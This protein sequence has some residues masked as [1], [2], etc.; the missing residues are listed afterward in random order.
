[1]RQRSGGSSTSQGYK[2]LSTFDA[3]QLGV[4]FSFRAG[5]NAA[6]SLVSS[7]RR[8]PSRVLSG[9]FELAGSLWQ[10]SQRP[11]VGATRLIRSKCPLD[12]GM[13]EG[14]FVWTHCPEPQLTAGGRITHRTRL[15]SPISPPRFLQPHLQADFLF[16]GSLWVDSLPPSTVLGP[17]GHE[18]PVLP[19]QPMSQGDWVG[20]FNSVHHAEDVHRKSRV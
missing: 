13:R 19:L 1:M 11:E 2:H 7:Q 18:H 12:P 15:G 4:L 8:V 14:Y 20:W 10:T 17:K 5:R 3:A 6:R 9:W 16:I